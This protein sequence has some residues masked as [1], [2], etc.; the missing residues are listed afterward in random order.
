MAGGS[1]PGD[2]YLGN[3]RKFCVAAVGNVSTERVTILRLV[4]E[5][6]AACS[7][8]WIPGAWISAQA[9]DVP[10]LGDKCRTNNREVCEEAGAQDLAPRLSW[11]P[12]E[13]MSVCPLRAISLLICFL[14]SHDDVRHPGREP[15]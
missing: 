4:R 15:C 12:R 8:G 6:V 11:R 1:R 9:D 7:T 2:K 14:H 13:S 10:N 3:S 5:W